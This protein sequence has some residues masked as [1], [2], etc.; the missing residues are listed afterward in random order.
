M[1]NKTFIG[2]CVESLHTLHGENISKLNIL[3]PTKRA[4]S[5]FK[6]ELAAIIAD[7]PIWQPKFSSISE[8]MSEITLLKEAERITLITELYKIYSRYHNESFDK[9]YYWG[10]VMLSDFDTIDNY[11]ADA[12]VLFSNIN[13]IK[14]IE[15]RFDYLSSEQK[16]MILQ[17]WGVFKNSTR[18]S[19]SQKEFLKLWNTL[20]SIYNEFGAHLSSMGIGYGGMIYRKAVEIIDSK[21]DIEKL[22]GREF[23][24]I[25][26]NALSSAE[27]SLFDYLKNSCNASFYWDS[28]NYYTENTMQES[29][30]FIR[31]NIKRY[32][33]TLTNLSRANFVKP[34]Q[35][36]IVNTPSD[37]LGCK[38]VAQ[39]IEELSGSGDKLSR[40]TAVVLTDESLLLPL[41]YSIP[42]CVEHFNVTSGYPLRLTQPYLLVEN[43]I[44]LQLS[45][46]CKSRDNIQIYHKELF[47]VV[48]NPYIQYALSEE[49]KSNY[50]TLHSSCE[51]HLMAYIPLKDVSIDK[52]TTLLFSIETTPEQFCDK[53]NNLFI[54]LLR[55]AADKFSVEQLEY[56]N[57]TLECVQRLKTSIKS[58]SDMITMNIFLSLLSK[59]LNS[60]NI[61]FE[62]EPLIGMQ[63]MG[64]LESRNLD[65]KNVIILSMCEDNYPSVKNINSL[66]PSNLRYGYGLPTLANHEAMYSYYFYRLLQ[67]AENIHI[68]YSSYAGESLSGE[69]SRYIHQL[70]LESPHK[71]NIV[72][73]NI[74]LKISPA[75][76]NE[77]I[78]PKIEKV[79]A[80]L[81]RFLNGDRKLSASRLYDYVECPLRFYFSSIQNIKPKTEI[82]DTLD[83]A[84]SGSVLHGVLEDIYSEIATKSDYKKAIG[85]VLDGVNIEAK[86]ATRITEKLNI[87]QTEFNGR[88]VAK[89]LELATLVK[90]ILTYDM[91]S[92][93]SFRI[94][95]LEDDIDGEIVFEDK[96]VRFIG[97]I[98]RV[99]TMSS[100][101]VRIIDYKSGK[102]NHTC[103]DLGEIMRSDS[104]KKSKP[105]FQTLLYSLLYKQK[106]GLSVQPAI[107]HARDILSELY[108]PQI[109]INKLILNNY[110]EVESEFTE[111]LNTILIELF[112]FGTPFKQTD[113]IDLCKYC[114]FNSICQR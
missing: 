6:M 17:F 45:A 111:G 110:N 97:K 76:R 13:D 84:T 62:G 101:E 93:S 47:R 39:V 19:A 31:D 63:I 18:Y 81:S 74:N 40:E 35:I 37:V 65:F 113:N 23:A 55:I 26:F 106:Y 114:Q 12:K 49:Q 28:D 7:K 72:V 83:A 4:I 29:G 20:Y 41:I 71:D 112:D 108:Q 87:P 85:A 69:P 30:M 60:A 67:R 56:I 48:N 54:E 99:D 78:V 32:G 5:F 109:T 82:T 53:I 70:K 34:K 36:T 98:D 73:K 15:D 50:N 59:Y 8:L 90:N 43:L 46:D 51:E 58:C 27:M 88:L 42:K 25:G 104:G 92:N 3:L 75:E 61:T 86:I 102:S 33:E 95:S 22:K 38:Y 9:F 64:I 79:Q 94:K 24:V 1:S 66:I 21:V 52:F 44:K 16:D 105:I 107:Y 57:K 96:S 14:D 11:G 77:I 68:V 103:K 100:G 2:E 80:G 89:E 91:N 10:G